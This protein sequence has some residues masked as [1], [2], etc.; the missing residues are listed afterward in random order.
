MKGDQFSAAALSY[1]LIQGVMRFVAHCTVRRHIRM[2]TQPSSAGNAG[3][4]GPDIPSFT[5]KSW[6]GQDQDN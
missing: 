6:M 4:C 3:Y 5:K 1:L 2:A